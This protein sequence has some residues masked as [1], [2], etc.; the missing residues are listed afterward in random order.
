MVTA[1]GIDVRRAF[2]LVFA[3]G[4][5]AAALGRASS[6]GVYFGAVDPGQGTSLLIFA[7]IVVVIGGM[8][9]IGGAAVAAVVVGLV[10]QFANY[11]ASAGLGDLA[12]VL[13]LAARAA[14]PARGALAEGGALR[15]APRPRRAGRPRRGARGRPDALG[16]RP[17]RLQRPARQPRHARPARALPRLRRGRAHLRP[18]LRLHRP[19]LVRPR[20]LLRARRLPD[21]DRADEVGVG[22]AGEPARRRRGGDRS[23]RSCSARSPCASAGSPSR[24]SRSPSPRPAGARAEEPRRPHR[25][26]GGARPQLRPAIPDVFV[27]VLNT[28]NLYWLALAYAAVVFLVVR[29]AVGSSP[30]A[31]SG[32]RSG[33]TSSGSR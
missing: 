9:S 6:A 3:I 26:R 22:A 7:F 14:R 25:R 8:G 17:R 33:R 27:G 15:S 23:S 21:R 10:Q 19:A 11:Y 29:W 32:R 1:L 12:V 16:R 28:K 4:G 30:R 20:A 2:T 24:W 31:T 18:A 13:L 5:C